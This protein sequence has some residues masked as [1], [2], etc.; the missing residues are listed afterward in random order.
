MSKIF[1]LISRSLTWTLTHTNTH[2]TAMH[3]AVSQRSEWGL[4]LWLRSR[5]RSLP[6]TL[7]RTSSHSNAWWCSSEGKNTFL[8]NVTNQDEF[9]GTRTRVQSLLHNSY[10][11]V[12]TKYHRF[13]SNS[14]DQT[15][16]R[17]PLYCNHQFTDK[18]IIQVLA[19]CLLLQNSSWK[20]QNIFLV[21]NKHLVESMQ[22]TNS[23]V[24][25]TRCPHGGY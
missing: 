25:G 5:C 2:F 8:I 13:C 12:V 14:H 20:I 22:S 3:N 18:L 15:T 24:D 21:G 17:L 11:H 19:K 1:T 4:T 9:L 10:P 6:G 7:G 16:G 23:L